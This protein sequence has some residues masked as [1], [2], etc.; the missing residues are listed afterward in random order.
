MYCPFEGRDGDWGRFKKSGLQEKITTCAKDKGGHQLFVYGNK[1]FYLKQGVIG[2]YPAKTN[3]ELTAEESVFKTS[4]AK[5][6]MS[7]GWGFAKITQYF[8]FNNLR[9]NMKIGLFPVG[10]Y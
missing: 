3:E 6:Q 8:E 10:A 5:Q 1:A 7:V 2:V 4:M 9:K